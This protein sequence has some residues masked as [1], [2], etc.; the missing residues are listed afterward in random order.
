MKN[1]KKIFAVLM[2]VSFLLLPG[3]ASAAAPSPM[4]KPSKVPADGKPSAVKTAPKPEPAVNSGQPK[5][6]TKPAPAQPPAV[7][8]AAAKPAKPKK[9]PKKAKKDKKGKQDKKTGKTDDKKTGSMKIA[10]KETAPFFPEKQVDALIKTAKSYTG[11]KYVYGGADP[12][13]FDC[14][15]YIMYIFKK[16]GTSVPRA[17]DDQYDIGRLVADTKK[18]VKGDLVFFSENRREIS[19][20]GLYLGGGNFIHASSSKGIR[21]DSLSNEYWKPRYAGAKHVTK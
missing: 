5:P 13:G 21:I 8:P 10:C 16:H 15:G 3:L 9:A 17:A 7:K 19:H 20:V 2:A 11:V 4:D 14:S 1:V 12:K 6:V 18:L